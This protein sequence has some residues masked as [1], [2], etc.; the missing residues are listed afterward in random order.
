METE[1]RKQRASERRHISNVR[2]VVAASAGIAALAFATSPG[3]VAA[4]GQDNGS[5][6]QTPIKHVI[7]IVGENRTFDHMF[8]T[9]KPAN[10]QSV[11]NLLSQGIVN[12]D[13]SPGPNFAKAH[14]YQATVTGTTQFSLATS[15]KSP[16]STLASP[17]TTGTATAARDTSGSPYA[18]YNP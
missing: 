7:V 4:A 18:T 9:Y 15:I 6:T 3:S 10:G 5:A 8:G 13:G 12:A 16:Y 17:N 2:V 11:Q 14:Q 1:M